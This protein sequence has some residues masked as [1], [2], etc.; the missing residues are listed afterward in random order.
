M[1]FKKLFLDHCKDKKYEINQNQLSI[2]EDL[3]YYYK[4]NFKQSFF[5]KIFK[6]EYS[7]LGY[8]LDIT[9]QVMLGLE[10]Q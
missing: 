2:I 4:E 6:K 7:K 8:C 3:K 1:N 9:W 5:K 10:K